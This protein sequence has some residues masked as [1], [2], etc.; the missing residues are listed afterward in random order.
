VA[1]ACNPA[2]L[3]AGVDEWLEGGI[4]GGDCPM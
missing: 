1:H 2:T 4:P 3:E